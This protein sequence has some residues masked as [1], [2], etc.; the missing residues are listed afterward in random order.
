MNTIAE[1]ASGSKT[2]R[3]TGYVLGGLVIL[4]LLL[5]AGIKLVPFDIV[6][7]SSAQLGLPTDPAFAR[8]LAILIL[9]GV[10][11]YAIPRT[12]V[13]GAILLSG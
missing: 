1:S 13:L 6:T 4:F 9:I 11:L 7:E 5:D 12:S 10:A 8:T 3:R 2:A